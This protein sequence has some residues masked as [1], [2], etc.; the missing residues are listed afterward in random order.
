[1]AVVW[2]LTDVPSNAPDVVLTDVPSSAPD[3]VLTDIP[4][5][6]QMWTSHATT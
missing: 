4:S 2:I 6:A 1:M 3:V 5:N